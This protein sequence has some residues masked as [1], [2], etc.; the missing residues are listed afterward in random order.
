MPKRNACG[1]PIPR[2]LK[3][4]LGRAWNRMLADNEWFDGEDGIAYGA[5]QRLIREWRE[6]KPSVVEVF[7]YRTRAYVSAETF[8]T[9]RRAEAAAER[10]LS[11]LDSVSVRVRTAYFRSV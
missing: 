5:Q 7:S 8:E 9:R 10:I 2:Q 4:A 11:R 1:E 6:N 3:G